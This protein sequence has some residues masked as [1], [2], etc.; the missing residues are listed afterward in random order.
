MHSLAEEQHKRDT[1]NSKQL[2]NKTQ[3]LT[4]ISIPYFILRLDSVTDCDTLSSHIVH[5]THC[6]RQLQAGDDR[7]DPV[8]TVHYTV[9]FYRCTEYNMGY[10]TP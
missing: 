9:T 10:D 2:H 4:L 6:Q 5:V 3:R 1:D 7:N 8:R